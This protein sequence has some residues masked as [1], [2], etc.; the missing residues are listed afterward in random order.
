[1]TGQRSMGQITP[2]K[3]YATDAWKKACELVAVLESEELL[4]QQQLKATQ[5][6][7]KEA[8]AVEKSTKTD[9]L[10][11]LDTEEATLPGMVDRGQPG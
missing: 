5:A 10:R 7:L 3:K 6:S 11:L 1:M 4:Q 9:L 2:S 8:R